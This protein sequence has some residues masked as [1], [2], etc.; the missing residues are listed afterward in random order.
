MVEH[1]K[2]GVTA[3][4][5]SL[6]PT[7]VYGNFVYSR[8]INGDSEALGWGFSPGARGQLCLKDQRV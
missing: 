5:G 2:A 4:G 1:K 3:P 7:F 6:G 8:S